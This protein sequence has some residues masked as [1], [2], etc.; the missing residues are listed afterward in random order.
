MESSKTLTTFLKFHQHPHDKSGLGFEKGTTFSKS[1]F[2]SE[3]CDF[4]G[5][6]GHF[7]F[8]C[9]HKKKQM[10]KFTNYA[11]LKK[12]WVLKSQIVPTTNILSS[13]R[14]ARV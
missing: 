11:R 1:K 8:K 14:P 12:I 9:I 4:C 3:K 10:S 6:S 13:K 5:K 2:I 7:E